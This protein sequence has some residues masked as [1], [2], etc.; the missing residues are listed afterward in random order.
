MNNTRLFTLPATCTYHI[1]TIQVE[2]VPDIKVS[3]GTKHWLETTVPWKGM[4]SMGQ[5][6]IK[7]G[8]NILGNF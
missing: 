4:S 3:L 1:G 2:L 6:L 8:T 5:Y 7:F